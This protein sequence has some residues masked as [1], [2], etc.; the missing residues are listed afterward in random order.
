[1]LPNVAHFPPIITLGMKHR[2]EEQ[3]KAQRQYDFEDNS[4]IYENHFSHYIL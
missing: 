3:S 2:L 1:M 4:D